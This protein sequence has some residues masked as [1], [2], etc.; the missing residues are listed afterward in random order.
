MG[1]LPLLTAFAIG[2]IE[3]AQLI[4]DAGAPTDS[5]DS[6]RQTILNNAVDAA[7]RSGDLSIID[8]A[9]SWGVNKN[10]RSADGSTVLHD[11]VQIQSL[12]VVQALL[13][14]GLDPRIKNRIGQTPLAK[15]INLNRDKTMIDALTRA[16]R[17]ARS[18]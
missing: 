13:D 1:S 4:R 12:A 6:S 15:A 7:S 2:D 5:H 3:C 11:A 8:V 16:A 17:C 9:I 18:I 14:R 10:D